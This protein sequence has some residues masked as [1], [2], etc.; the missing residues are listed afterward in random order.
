MQDLAAFQHKGSSMTWCVGPSVFTITDFSNVY[1]K[2]R[3]SLEQVAL[4]SWKI[5][6]AVTRHQIHDFSEVWPITV[7]ITKKKNFTAPSFTYFALIRISLLKEAKPVDEREV[8][9]GK[10]RRTKTSEH[11]GEVFMLIPTTK[12]SHSLWE[13]QPQPPAVC[14]NS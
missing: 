14:G 8:W 6:Q 5:A 4:F 9:H 11:C 7:V 3:S 1:M 13:L 12:Q 10:R 2:M